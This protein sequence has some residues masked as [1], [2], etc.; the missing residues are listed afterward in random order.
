MNQRGANLKRRRCSRQYRSESHNPL[1][2]CQFDRTYKRA[3]QLGANGQRVND[4]FGAKESGSGF[5]EVKAFREVG[6]ESLPK[7]KLPRK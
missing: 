5:Q 7:E 6:G 2:N 1:V 3:W 4:L